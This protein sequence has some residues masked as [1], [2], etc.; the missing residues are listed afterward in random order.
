MPFILTVSRYGN[1]NPEHWNVYE[2]TRKTKAFWFVNGWGGRER[3]VAIGEVSAV[4]EDEAECEALRAKALEAWRRY[5]DKIKPLSDAMRDA[6][7]HIRGFESAR[8][9]EIEAILAG[10]VS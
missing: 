9:I 1:G 10:G 4:C 2:V 5:N 3:R 6:R 7:E 8:D